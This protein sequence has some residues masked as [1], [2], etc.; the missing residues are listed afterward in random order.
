MWGDDSKEAYMVAFFGDNDYGSIQQCR[1][2]RDNEL[3]PL[4]IQGNKSF[5]RIER[6]DYAVIADNYFALL[7]SDQGVNNC[8][9]CLYMCRYLKIH[10]NMFFCD[11]QKPTGLHVKA[12]VP[13]GRPIEG[14]LFYNNRIEG[15]GLQ[16]RLAGATVENIG[17]Q[18]RCQFYGNRAIGGQTFYSWTSADG[19]MRLNGVRFYNNTIVGMNN[20][21]NGLGGRHDQAPEFN[22]R[23]I[24]TYNNISY[25]CTNYMSCNSGRPKDPPGLA[26]IAQWSIFDRNCLWGHTNVIYADSDPDLMNKTWA[27]WTGYI[28]PDPLRITDHNSVIAD[29]DFVDEVDYKLNPGSPCEALGR[30]VY[31]TFGEVG[32]VIPAGCYVA[33]DEI[34]GIRD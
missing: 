30:D 16:M 9:I 3:D 13:R 15:Y 1:L 32:A 34:I 27:D 18:H 25:N 29:P 28:D 20:A 14:L 26:W 19:V 31:G 17:E 11:T 23:N 12:G 24:G 6:N 7:G 21:A 4:S 10:N 33:G 5:I 8:A 2:I 22:P